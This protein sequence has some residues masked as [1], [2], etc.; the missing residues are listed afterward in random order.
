[1]RQAF[2]GSAA[3]DVSVDPQNLPQLLMWRYHYC[4]EQAPCFKSFQ[5]LRADQQTPAAWGQ[6]K[7]GGPVRSDKDGWR[8]YPKGD[9]RNLGTHRYKALSSRVLHERFLLVSILPSRT[10]KLPGRF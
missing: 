6:D 2:K 1:M 9:L 8:Y 3:S 7:G 5:K 4:K 10:S